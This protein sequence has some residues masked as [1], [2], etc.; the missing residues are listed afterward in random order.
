MHARNI[1]SQAECGRPAAFNE[2]LSAIYQLPTHDR[3]HPLLFLTAQIGSLPIEARGAAFKSVANAIDKL[4]PEHRISLLGRL[5]GQIRA[6]AVDEELPALEILLGRTVQLSGKDASNGLSRILWSF[7]GSEATASVL[8]E[9][10]SSM[11]A[12]RPADERASLVQA[13]AALFDRLPR[14][15]R[16]SAFGR[17]IGMTSGMADMAKERVHL[18]LEVDAVR[19]LPL[20]AR[21]KA[22]SMLQ[23][24]LS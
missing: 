23:V 7:C 5:A 12:R 21:A 20:D 16:Q 11:A 3:W 4:S 9:R 24:S 19:K 14:S 15:K 18:A 2:V 8:F 6:L 17:L 22:R 13:L 10:A 1:A